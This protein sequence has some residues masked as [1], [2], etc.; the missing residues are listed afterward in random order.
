MWAKTV[1]LPA[2]INLELLPFY[3]YTPFPA[4]LPLLKCIL[5]VVF[6]EGAQHRLLFALDHLCCVKM[7]AYQL[8]L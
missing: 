3:A 5:Q 6:S 2:T 4:L 1:G 7:T 8:Y